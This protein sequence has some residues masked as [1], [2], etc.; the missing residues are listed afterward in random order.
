M[1][2]KRAKAIMQRVFSTL[3]FLVFLYVTS[4]Q[5]AVVFLG[6]VNDGLGAAGGG[7]SGL[8]N[9][10]WD[11]LPSILRPGDP[12]TRDVQEIAMALTAVSALGALFARR[13]WRER[14]IRRLRG[15]YVD[16][17]LGGGKP[18]VRRRS[19]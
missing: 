15:P 1:A 13:W 16:A 17:G 11:Q 9:L 19:S 8:A 2:I 4:W 7:F 10:W 5:V 12:R 14:E 3:V 18:T 6:Y